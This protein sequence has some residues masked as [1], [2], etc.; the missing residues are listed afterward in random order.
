M[1]KFERKAD[2]T[3]L[4]LL[5][6]SFQGMV[7][8]ARLMEKELGKERAHELIYRS[9]VEGDLQLI[10]K[11]LKGRKPIETFA[12]FKTLMKGLHES[13]SARN[14]FTITYP[15]DNDEEIEFHATECILAKVFKEMGAEDLGNVM[16]CEPDFETT[17]VYCPSVY[18][19]R[20]KTLMKG[21]GCC[22]T[23]YCWKKLRIGK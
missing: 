4:D 6:E 12:D 3:Y 11:Q 10:R 7:R 14:L 9:R 16:C 23:K 22:D 17:P 21:D 1:H 8:L 15:V 2:I 20:S 18:L 5:R 13:P 19:K